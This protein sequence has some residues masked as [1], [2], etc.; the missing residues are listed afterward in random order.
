MRI[1]FARTDLANGL[2][3]LVVEHH[4][5][6][7]VAINLTLRS[8]SAAN[9]PDCAG[10]ADLTADL[11]VSGTLTRNAD[12]IAELVDSLGATMIATTGWDST[13][14][15]AA[16]LVVDTATLLGLI[17]EIVAA[18]AFP[19]DELEQLRLRR[20]TE[21]KVRR[22]SPSAVASDTFAEVL[23]PGHPFGL[24]PDGTIASVETVRRSDLTAFHA[25]HYLPGNAVLVIVGDVDPDAVVRSAEGAFGAWR[26]APV[27][28]TSIPNPVPP[29]GMR[30]V[31]VDRPDLTQT[32]IRIGHLGVARA[33]PD[34]FPLTVAN[35][36]LGGGGFS[37]R[38]LDR[39]R[40]Q[41]GYTYGLSSVFSAR[42][43]GGPFTISTFTPNATVPEVVGEVLAV[44]R[45]F[46]R[47]GADRVEL[48]AARNFFV[49]GYPRS[50]ETPSGIA[51]ALT[52]VE[53]YGLGEDY[54]ETWQNRLGAV[55]SEQVIETAARR[56]DPE[57]IVLALVGR[58]EEV[59]G[60]LRD[61]LEAEAAEGSTPPRVEIRPHDEQNQSAAG[62]L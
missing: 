5:L 47:E 59:A 58:A 16:G 12:G 38:L 51:T 10:L 46:R 34:W 29:R 52:E 32:Q 7:T 48:D 62:G 19:E 53:L 22:D 43:A 39:I 30:A 1:P 54:I 49:C 4:G 9:P 17:A 3:I 21:L 57:N 15:S 6:P 11:L 20:L 26:P 50:F 31:I 41:K 23:Y 28:E 60:R 40:V 13:S 18:P 8:G 35:Y 55:S 2:R 14:L 42:R 61:T 45:E 36:I 27:A 24:S 56:F 33:A 25:A 44:T 37:S